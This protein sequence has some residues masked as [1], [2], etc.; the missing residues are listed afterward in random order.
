M[1]LAELDLRGDGP[2]AYVQMDMKER[3]LLEELQEDPQVSVVLLN[4][5]SSVENKRNSSEVF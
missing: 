4:S 5:P 2:G 3:Y 1:Q